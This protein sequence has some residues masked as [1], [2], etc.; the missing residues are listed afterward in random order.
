[1]FAIELI[2]SFSDSAFSVTVDILNIKYKTKIPY[3]DNQYIIN[4]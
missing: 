4:F 3:H 1:M 2:D